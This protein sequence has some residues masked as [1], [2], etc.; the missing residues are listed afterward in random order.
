[1]S[2]NLHKPRCLVGQEAV[3]E[4]PKGEE[5]LPAGSGVFEIR[6]GGRLLEEGPRLP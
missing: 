3:G 4:A 2:G 5:Y 1:M 6:R